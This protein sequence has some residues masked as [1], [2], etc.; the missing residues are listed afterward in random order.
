MS[1]IDGTNTDMEY[2]R[3]RFVRDISKAATNFDT[4]IAD[5]TQSVVDTPSTYPFN[6]ERLELITEGTVSESTEFED[7]DGGYKLSVNGDATDA[8]ELRA[9]QRV[10][11]IPNYELLF[12]IAYFMDAEL[13]AGQR[14]EAAFTDNGRDNGY[15]IRIE[16]DSREAF[17][18]NGGTVVDSKEWGVNGA[19]DPYERDS[20]DE[21]LPQ[22]LRT[23]LSWYGDGNANFTLTSPGPNAD[24]N[25][26][27]VAKVANRQDV[28][29]GEINL[30]LSIRLECTEA[31]SAATLNA[32]SMGALVQGTGSVTNRTKPANNFG[33]GGD[34]GSASFTPILALRRQL[35]KPQ[36][37]T[38]LD[39]FEIVPD[40]TM[41]VDAMAF[42]D[43]ETDASDWDVPP[44]QDPE[45]TAIEQTTN[46]STFPTDGDGN[47]EGRLIDIVAS[48]ASGNRGERSEADVQS[49]FYE[50]E[51]LVF[52]ARTKSAS[53]A[54]VDLLYETR[55]EW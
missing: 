17:I 25:N 45:N 9:R 30:K 39:S 4:L 6:S 48:T 41:E 46:I 13:E 38:Q 20:V 44:Q 12:G 33:L 26:E 47:P 14:L 32:L 21:T 36:I 40:S 50:D 42:P 23:F 28:A 53:D 43:T 22:V 18:R 54:N 15:F 52:L 31:T 7:T 35:D 1:D 37:A 51:Y 2:T 3:T 55:Q 10:T 29:T 5:G 11:Y 24:L 16:N 34:I 27:T 8:I 19:T 49:E